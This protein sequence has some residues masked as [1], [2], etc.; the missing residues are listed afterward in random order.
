M[1]TEKNEHTLAF[2]ERSRHMSLDLASV[3]V[4]LTKPLRGFSHA[5][6]PVFLNQNTEQEPLKC[7]YRITGSVDGKRPAAISASAHGLRIVPMLRYGQTPA[8]VPQPSVYSA[9]GVQESAL[10]IQEHKEAASGNLIHLSFIVSPECLS[11]GGFESTVRLRVLVL[12]P[13]EDIVVA[14]ADSERFVVMTRELPSENRMLTYLRA[15]GF[16]IAA[17]DH[18][19]HD[20]WKKSA[21]QLATKK[22]KIPLPT[23]LEHDDEQDND[24]VV[25][26]MPDGKFLFTL[27]G[28]ARMRALT[29]GGGGGT[30]LGFGLGLGAAFGVPAAA[31]SFCAAHEG[32]DERVPASATASESAPR[33]RRV[34]RRLD[35]DAADIQQPGEVAV[36]ARE[37]SSDATSSLGSAIG[38]VGDTGACDDD[39]GDGDCGGGDQAAVAASDVLEWPRHIELLDP[40]AAAAAQEAAAAPEM[41]EVAKKI[42]ALDSAD[43][44]V[45]AAGFSAAFSIPMD[46]EHFQWSPNK[47]FGATSPVCT[48]FTPTAAPFS[49]AVPHASMGAAVS[50]DAIQND[51]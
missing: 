24:P 18:V 31:G 17:A 5:H 43:A 41:D 10:Q 20:L 21:T 33:T 34:K 8:A 28:M 22:R 13:D 4:T 30:A 14:F 6:Y 19:T 51:W 38:A 27:S 40:T 29:S 16:A 11:T 49:T 1:C 32:A 50:F 9:T 15:W 23:R 39:C 2:R 35:S 42:L 44:S 37:P 25:V 48:S 47:P 45:L 7:V 36:D 12:H 26:S 3:T 46:P